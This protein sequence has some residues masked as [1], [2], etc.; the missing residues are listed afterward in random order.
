MNLKTK[1]V[2]TRSKT[3]IIFPE[4]LIHSEFSGFS[5]TS[6]GFISF[7]VDENN[8]PTCSCYGESISLGLKSNPVEDTLL[9]KRQLNM[10]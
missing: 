9:A 10:L 1:Y 3:I 7:G 6:A 5:P 4:L 8:N 2:I